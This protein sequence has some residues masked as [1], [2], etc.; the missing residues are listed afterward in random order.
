MDES[1]NTNFPLHNQRWSDRRCKGERINEGQIDK[2][3]GYRLRKLS[4]VGAK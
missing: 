2:K 4:W 1:T 3:N